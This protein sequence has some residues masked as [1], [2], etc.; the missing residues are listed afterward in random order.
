MTMEFD[1][2]EA[3]MCEEMA[4]DLY[5][6][7]VKDGRTITK[8]FKSGERTFS[9][10]LSIVRPEPET[11]SLTSYENRLMTIALNAGAE[12]VAEATDAIAWMLHD[13]KIQLPK[14]AK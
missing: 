11:P 10:R 5:D 13:W 6:F 4:S 14:E 1:P 7:I 2:M 12:T 9:M 8:Y 3:A